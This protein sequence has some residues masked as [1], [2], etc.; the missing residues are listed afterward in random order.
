MLATTGT[1][2]YESVALN[3]IGEGRDTDDLVAFMV[4][5]LKVDAS[6]LRPVVIDLIQRRLLTDSEGRV[7]LSPTGRELRATIRSGIEANTSVLYGDLPP[8]DLNA[9]GRVLTTITER[10]NAL[11]DRME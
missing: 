6:V 9:A 11:L 8:E 1:T 2:F 5:G 3:T 4:R 10:A 7:E